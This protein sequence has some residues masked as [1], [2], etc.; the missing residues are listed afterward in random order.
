MY[1]TKACNEAF[2]VNGI[3][4]GPTKTWYENG[5]KRYEGFYTNDAQSG[6]W[7]NWDEAGNLITEDDKGKK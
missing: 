4:N 2:Y 3:K 5:N 1:F 6:K 7:K